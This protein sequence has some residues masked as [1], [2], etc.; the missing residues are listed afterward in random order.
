[1]ESEVEIEVEPLES[2]ELEPLDPL[3]LEPL[4]LDS[5]EP[6]KLEPLGPLDPLNPLETLETLETSVS[7]DPLEPLEPEKDT[8]DLETETV[9]EPDP[10]DPEDTGADVT[11][12]R[13]TLSET[14]I[15]V[16]SAV[17][18][19]KL[20]VLSA[21]SKELNLESWETD[22]AAAA[23]EIVDDKE[24]LWIATS[25]AGKDESCRADEEIV[26]V[27]FQPTDLNNWVDE[28]TVLRPVSE[29]L[30]YAEVE[31]NEEVSRL[32]AYKL[33]DNETLLDPLDDDTSVNKVL[34]DEA[35]TDEADPNIDDLSDEEAVEKAGSDEEA[36]E[37]KKSNE[38]PVNVTGS[39]ED[40]VDV[41]ESDEESNEDEWV[42]IN[43]LPSTE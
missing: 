23:L 6:S 20:L 5:L 42:L 18:S 22:K 4:E 7:F 1:M 24:G 41:T 27:L 9:T 40:L 32:K 31:I 12:L 13:I 36:V 3:K 10:L 14:E 25:A 17:N 29:E 8:R 39:D 33:E 26:S 37:E 2:L 28:E 38:D 30:E 34:I 19:D 35:D 21:V 11:E 15:K 43:S 16:D